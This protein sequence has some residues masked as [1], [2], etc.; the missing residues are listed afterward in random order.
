ME[1]KKKILK[2]AKDKN[3]VILSHNYQRDEIQAIADYTGDSL[4]LAKIAADNKADIIV[5]C[6]VHFMAES[7][8][9][10]S[11]QKKVILPYKTAGC[12][13]A[14]MADAESVLKMKKKYPYAKV[15][16]YINSTAAVKAVSDVCCTSSNAV[17]IVSRIDADEIIFVPDKN[18]GSYVQGF[19]DKKIILWDGFCPVHDKYTK[20]EL[21]KVKEQYP[22]ALVI[23]HPE[24]RSEIRKIAD[25]VLSTGQ[26]VEFCRNN[27]KKTIIMGTENGMLFKL[28]RSAPDNIYIKGSE[29]FICDDMKKITLEMLYKSLVSEET[30]ITV[31]QEIADKAVSSLTKMLELSC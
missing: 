30:V 12:P 3:A 24:C 28:Q 8:S 26:M 4:E 20:D 23:V 22:E 29:R 31:N 16:A 9:I 11:P 19:T 13:M 17:K 7:A 15:V 27:T 14:D 6:G 18:L 10:L 2:I 5:F 25:K 21:I 1:L